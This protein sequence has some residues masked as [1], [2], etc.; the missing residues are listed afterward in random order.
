MGAW[1]GGLEIEGSW[2]QFGK[3]GLFQWKCTEKWMKPTDR[4]NKYKRGQ[5]CPRCFSFKILLHLKSP[6]G[7]NAFFFPVLTTSRFFFQDQIHNFQLFHEEWLKRQVGFCDRLSVRVPKQLLRIPRQLKI[8]TSEILLANSQ[9]HFYSQRILLTE[10]ASQT[11]VSLKVWE[12]NTV[13]RATLERC[14]T[15]EQATGG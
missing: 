8:L 9:M 12:Q 7:K 10:L 5:C 14:D 15:V 6:T 3:W 1:A 13:E 2:D 4:G 11:F